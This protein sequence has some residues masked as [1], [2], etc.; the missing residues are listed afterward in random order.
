MKEKYGGKPKLSEMRG[1]DPSQIAGM[2]SRAKKTK[3]Q[4]VSRYLSKLLR[5]QPEELNL[6]LDIHGWV[7]V[8]DLIDALNKDG[9]DITKDD[10]KVIVHTNDKKRFEFD[11]QIAPHK[12]RASQGHSASLAVEL[13]LQPSEPPISLFHGSPASNEK[14][15]L[16][17]GLL[18]MGRNKVHLT[19]NIDTA[20]KVGRRKDGS[21]V[22]FTVPAK[23]M[24]E[25]GF[26]FYKTQN[27]VWLIEEVPSN[28]LRILKTEIPK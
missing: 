25:L 26:K 20:E 17:K 21:L 1:K 23:A 3:L 10:L 8:N 22:I 15:I 11:R 7:S 5:H 13:D 19:A 27:E 9:A 16:V 18:K 12:I 28:Y 24:H 6:I 14:D 4:K 2:L